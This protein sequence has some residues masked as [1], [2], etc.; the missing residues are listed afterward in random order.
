MP[1][2]ADVWNDTTGAIAV[3]LLAATVPG[4]TIETRGRTTPSCNMVGR[5]FA[6]PDER[7]CPADLRVSSILSRGHATTL[8][9]YSGMLIAHA[10]EFRTQVRGRED[11]WRRC[12]STPRTIE[13]LH[14]HGEQHLAALCLRLGK[15]RRAAVP[16]C[17]KENHASAA[18][19]QC[20]KQKKAPCFQA[21]VPPLAVLSWPQRRQRATVFFCRLRCHGAGV[22]ALA[23]AATASA[24]A[25]HAGGG[26]VG[27]AGCNILFTLA[28]HALGSS[29]RL[30]YI[31]RTLLQQTVNVALARVPA[32][33]LLHTA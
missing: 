10:L 32:S 33:V 15:C 14:R 31:M 6:Q 9:S 30:V 17:E 5:H 13:L 28:Y 18:G 7:I 23:A 8:W 24:A 25:E 29:R 11:G 2:P 4:V 12:L 16:H 22:A 19:R 21:A 20:D 26:R 3:E 27:G 1:A